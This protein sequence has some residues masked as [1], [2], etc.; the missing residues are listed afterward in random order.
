[1]LYNRASKICSTEAALNNEMSK[2]KENL[3]KNDYSE[4]LIE[5]TISKCKQIKQ[6]L[7]KDKKD[8]GPL[9][10]LP[11]KK[12]TS[13]NI[14]RVAKTFNIKTPLHQSKL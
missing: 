3:K 12:R 13:E 8:D 2:I 11:Y 5:T 7:P 10:I 9:L 6:P 1:M 14:R 4:I